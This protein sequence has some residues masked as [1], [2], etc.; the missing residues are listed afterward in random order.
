MN[1]TKVLLKT[2][3]LL[4]IFFADMVFAQVYD[5]E[6]QNPIPTGKT[7]LDSYVLESGKD[8]IIVGRHGLIMRSDD[9][10]T[11][12]KIYSGTTSY[13]T[14]IH[15]FDMNRGWIVGDDGTILFTSDGG[16]SWTQQETGTIRSLNAIKFSNQNFGIAVGWGVIL[17]TTN[18]GSN[19][20][21]ISTSNTDPLFDLDFLDSGDAY[22]VGSSSAILRSTNA[23]VDWEKL[24]VPISERLVGV[25]FI[26]K[27]EGWVVGWQG[28]LLH[29]TDGGES[30]AVS[31]PIS[32]DLN[33]VA[34]VNPSLGFVAGDHGT[35]MK[36]TDGG[37]TWQS[38]NSTGITSTLFS[39]NYSNNQSYNNVFVGGDYGHLL[40]STD[41]GATWEDLR[42]SFTESGIT[43]TFFTDPT[44][45]WVIS[46]EGIFKTEDGGSS[47]DL[48]DNG[49][50]NSPGD[51]ALFF[52]NND[53]G[54]TGTYNGKIFKTTNS[55]VNWTEIYNWLGRSIQEIF[56]IDENMGLV[57]AGSNNILKTTDAGSSWT[58]IDIPSYSYSMESIYFSTPLVGFIVG[59]H[60]KLLRSL[61]GG[62][63]W[64]SIYA[65]TGYFKSV[66]FANV[67]NGF[68][69]GLDGLFYKTID[70]G[71]SWFPQTFNSSYNLSEVFFTNENNGWIVGSEDNNYQGLLLYTTDGGTNWYKQDSY[72]YGSLY[73]CFFFD[74]G[75]GWVGGA[76]GNLVKYY[77]NTYG[78]QLDLYYPL[79]GASLQIDQEIEILWNA[80]NIGNVK[81]D[82]S[83][84]NGINW[85]T[86]TTVPGVWGSYNWIIPY[87]TDNEFLLRISDVLN[88]SISVESGLLIA[89]DPPAEWTPVTNIG[90]YSFY[91]VF[92][93][94]EDTGW[95]LTSSKIFS[96]SDGG[97]NWVEQIGGLSSMKSIYFVDY[98][99]GWAVGSQGKI[100]K[101]T[102]GGLNWLNVGGLVN[103]YLYDIYFYD[104]LNGWVAV[105]DGSILKSIDG[106]NNWEIINIPTSSD[107][108]KV[109]FPDPLIGYAIAADFGEFYK[110]FDGG[111]NWLQLNLSG[112]QNGDPVSI[113]FINQDIGWLITS[114]SNCLKTIDGG[115]NWTSVEVAQEYLKDVVFLDEQTG[116]IAGSNGFTSRTMDGGSTWEYVSSG[117]EDHLQSIY[118]FDI[119]NGWACGGGSLLKYTGDATPFVQVLSPNGNEDFYFGDQIDIEWESSNTDNVK[120]E[121]STN[122]GSY[123][124]TIVSSTVASTGTFPWLVPNIA[125][126]NY[127]VKISNVENSAFYDISDFTFSIIDTTVS[128]TIT[129][130]NGGESLNANQIFPITWNQINVEN[131]KLEYSIDAGDN[132]SQIIASFP[133]VVGTYH[134]RV[135]NTPSENCLVR[136]SDNADEMIVDVSETVFTINSTSQ[137]LTVITP[138]GG[139]VFGVGTIVQINWS[140]GGG[141]SPLLST[142]NEEYLSIGKNKNLDFEIKGVVENT[143]INMVKLQYT[144]NDGVNWILIEDGIDASQQS[145]DWSVPN[146][147][148]NLCKV[149]VSNSENPEQNDI[150]NAVFT[151]SDDVLL[152]KYVVE[153][154]GD[155]G[156]VGDTVSASVNI[157]VQ[158]GISFSSGFVN[159][160]YF[161]NQLEFLAID[162]TNSVISGSDT[163]I[164]SNN[165]DSL[166]LISF[167]TPE[168][169]S[170]SGLLF[171]I[172]F[173]ITNEVSTIIPLHIDSVLIDTG[174][175][176]VLTLDGEIRILQPIYGDVDLNTIVQPYDASYLL[177]YLVGYITELAPQQI[178]NADVTTDGSLSALD[179]SVIL[180]YTAGLINEF[181]FLRVIEPSGLFDMPVAVEYADSLFVVP[182]QISSGDSIYSFECM[183][184]YSSEYIYY[185]G[186]Q[187]GE[188]L[189]NYTVQSRVQNNK[190][191]IV[192]AADQPS[193]EDGMFLY[194]RF[195][196]NYQDQ[197]E[198][199]Y[200]VFSELRLNESE[201]QTEIDST[202]ISLVVGVEENEEIPHSFALEQNYPNPFNPSTTIS[203]SVP[204]GNISNVDVSLKVFDI[205]GREIA[206][207][208]NTQQKAGNYTVVFD[209]KALSSGVYVYILKVGA[210]S[211]SRK[212]LL[213]K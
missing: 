126:D 33:A 46:N 9:G 24:D 192:G 4:L 11:W 120:V 40:H 76:N 142:G 184:E 159:L 41:F 186:L 90:Q 105:E 109:F 152:F 146:I 123:W 97:I 27:Y 77:F 67:S 119:Y 178:V 181:P 155:V 12:D 154:I 7:L 98:M 104:L 156:Q 2:F 212:M 151:I 171:K 210:L 204:N 173:I 43:K 25:D 36:T 75:I 51:K 182:V 162:T 49:I 208:V 82:Y 112:G 52:T 203:Y 102:D 80:T 144:F 1:S 207:L 100:L 145:Y 137:S 117:V 70:G 29:T 129:D 53:I 103:K 84:N 130:P 188:S 81:L 153:I 20:E 22:A 64:Q 141:Q 32:Y 83:T 149:K 35:I 44:H 101:T 122:N 14:D 63:T 88:P 85:Y 78:P 62:N 74:Y 139:E 175:Y 39:I 169:I 56:F 50:E 17:R 79:S 37:I 99:N 19:W 34:F 206:S 131:I 110:S 15:F 94:G 209:A 127:L 176:T 194:L 211:K 66:H 200:L 106:G 5:Y 48:G 133:A 128:L 193:L 23:G 165:T 107:V 189:N 91:D 179:A 54:Y 174:E 196:K 59:E 16:Y 183:F 132:W 177:K 87:I 113:Y 213:L 124:S 58:E 202:L 45:G 158:D 95:A 116:W 140:N 166:L 38:V 68:A 150:S 31:F 10:I 111:V 30:W 167:A 168:E 205:L 163:Y 136:I 73:S 60:G 199:S 18:S 134:W 125:S 114:H 115:A 191:K 147:P 187:Y 93:I 3:L 86:I 6:S 71:T 8:K 164:V 135:P 170:E 55:G 42:T 201:F 118:F 160:S 65:G 172:D 198:E 161:Q 21:Q 47:W 72:V 185:D 92:F 157:D 28:T 197:F 195:K 180:Q 13:L 57:L 96:T 89:N 108:K 143:D 26:D 148:S 190:I 69:V 121:Y 138:N 61:D